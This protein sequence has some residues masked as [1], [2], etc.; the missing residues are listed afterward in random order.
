MILF[1]PANARRGLVDHI[2]SKSK[3][4]DDAECAARETVLW[5]M[6]GANF[7]NKVLRLLG[8]EVVARDEQMCEVLGL[9]KQLELGLPDD[10]T[11]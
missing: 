9:L 2:V 4:E 5:L 6:F 10:S 11:A 1:I 7:I 8:P 3:K